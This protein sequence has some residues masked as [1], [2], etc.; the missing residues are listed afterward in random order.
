MSGV[1]VWAPAASRVRA[2]VGSD[3]VELSPAGPAT[4]VTS[5]RTAITARSPLRWNGAYGE[6][7]EAPVLGRDTDQVLAEVLGLTPP[8]LSGLRDRGVI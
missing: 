8:E 4:T 5:A 7:G 1:R 2:Q 6:P 3:Y